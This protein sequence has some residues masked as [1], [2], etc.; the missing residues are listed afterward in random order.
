MI[1]IWQHLAKTD[2]QKRLASVHSTV[3]RGSLIPQHRFARLEFA[4]PKASQLW[5]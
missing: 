2:M 5:R 3:G 1:G 4:T